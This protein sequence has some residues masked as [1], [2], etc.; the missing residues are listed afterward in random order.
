M[1]KRKVKEN[2][3]ETIIDIV[4]AKDSISDYINEN[5]GMVFGIIGLILLG[6]IGYFGYK[7]LIVAPKEAKAAE[8]IIKAQEM[9]A[10]DSFAL[11]LT[12]PGGG[13]EGFVDIADNYGG[14]ATGNTAKYYAGVSYLNLGRFEDAVEYLSGVSAKGS[15]LPIMK[16]GNLGDAYSELGQMDKARGAY[17]K[18]VNASGNE[19]L[20]PYFMQKLAFLNMKEGKMEAA[21]NLFTK[22]K[23][24]YPKSSVAAEVDKYLAK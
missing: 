15:I 5:K 17:E 13:Y 3:D 2:S 22:I 9:F 21:Q 16:H 6:L 14:T 18:A 19:F 11:A 1:T 10:K 12:N 20:T 4:E 24:D 8:Q 7:Y 23:N